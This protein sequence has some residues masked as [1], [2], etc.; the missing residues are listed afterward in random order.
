M[1]FRT[2]TTDDIDGIREVARASLSASYGHAL[3]D[4]L[5]DEAVETWYGVDG[6]ADDLADENAVFLVADTDDGR[7]VGFVQSYYVPSEPPTGEI[8]WLHVAPDH[9]GCGIGTDLLRGVEERLV[10]R[11]VERIEGRVLAANES[12]GEFYEGEGF[13][14]DGERE[15]EIGGESFLER[16][17]VEPTYAG[18]PAEGT[19][20]S[21][22]ESLT[23]SDGTAVY[24]AYD[25]G[26]RA[27]RAPFYA[28]YTDSERTERYG[29]VCGNCESTDVNVDTMDGVECDACGNRR[30]PIR[31]DA[32]YL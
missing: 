27:S 4:D 25:E 22:T 8:D 6:I 1:E 32:A 11:G 3:S 24:V 2:P 10:D 19:E 17:Y 23:T 13:D 20:E 12:G 5:I 29:Y 18:S 9:R 26:E 14:S 15:V 16:S 28:T 31:W 30:K 21:T 7:V